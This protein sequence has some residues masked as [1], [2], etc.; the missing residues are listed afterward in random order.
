[1]S[2]GEISTRVPYNNGAMFYPLGHKTTHDTKSNELSTSIMK[3]SALR[4]M[5]GICVVS[6]SDNLFLKVRVCQ[7]PDSFLWQLAFE[8]RLNL[9]SALL[10]ESTPDGGRKH[11]SGFR[12]V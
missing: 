2:N 12:A 11:V 7:F 9:T 6:R 10:S 4:W 8:D 3:A 5:L 1:M